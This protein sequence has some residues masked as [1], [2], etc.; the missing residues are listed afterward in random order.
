MLIIFI[1]FQVSSE[2]IKPSFVS[3]HSRNGNDQGF[4]P[5]ASAVPVSGAAARATCVPAMAA[6]RGDPLLPISKKAPIF[7][8]KMETIQHTSP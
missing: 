3:E 4:P 5:H 7:F 2:G 8:F 1:F 6:Q